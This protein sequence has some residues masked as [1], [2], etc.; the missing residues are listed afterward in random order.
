MQTNNPLLVTLAIDAKSQLFFNYLRQKY[1]PADI[2]YLDAH[3]MLFH[4]LPAAEK[5]ISAELELMA[6]E[7]TTF[8]MEVTDVACIGRGV[9]YKIVSPQLSWLHK[10]LQQQWQRWLIPQDTQKLWPH[11]TVQN[12]VDHFAAKALAIEL[13]ADFEQFEVTATGFQLWEY[14]GG[15]WEFISQYNFSK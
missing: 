5:S 2:N 3:L 10:Q 14:Q 7:T 8:N 13:A 15:P 9:A 6:R 11:I 1:F 12:K 4:N